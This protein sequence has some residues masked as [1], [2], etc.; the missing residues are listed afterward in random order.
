MQIIRAGNQQLIALVGDEQDLVT[1]SRSKSPG[2]G[3]QRVTRLLYKTTAPPSTDVAST[4]SVLSSSDYR[5]LTVDVAAGLC[6]ANIVCR[7]FSRS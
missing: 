2:M 1:V 4:A 7:C 5:I 3:S 6:A